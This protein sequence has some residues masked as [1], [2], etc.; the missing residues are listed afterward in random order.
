MGVD[1]SF[2]YSVGRNCQGKWL[3]AWARTRRN[4]VRRPYVGGVCNIFLVSVACRKS[5]LPLLRKLTW[6]LWA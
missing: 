5:V 1:F 4:E 3:V 2:E 6:K